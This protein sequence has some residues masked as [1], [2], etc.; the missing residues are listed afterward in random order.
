MNNHNARLSLLV[1]DH[2][3]PDSDLLLLQCNLLQAQ[4]IEPSLALS[5]RT[6]RDHDRRLLRLRGPCSLEPMRS[7]SGILLLDLY[8]APYRRDVNRDP[9]AWGMNS[10]LWL[11]H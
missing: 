2:P 3:A 11:K 8:P 5:S 10:L 4:L 6:S 1:L 7:L 9:R